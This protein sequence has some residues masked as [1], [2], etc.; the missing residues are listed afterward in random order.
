MN[1]S[2]DKRVGGHPY[3][4]AMTD[5]REHLGF[6][7]ISKCGSITATMFYGLR[8]WQPIET[9]EQ[10]GTPLYTAIRNPV[11][12]LLSSIP[13]T[14][15]RKRLLGEDVSGGFHLPE[16][17]TAA[18]LQI[19]TSSAQGL[20]IE[21]IK[22]IEQMGTFDAHHEGMYKF[23]F[24]DSGKLYGNPVVVQTET[25]SST[26]PRIAARH[27]W[28]QKMRRV[29]PFNSRTRNRFEPDKSLDKVRTYHQN[30]PICRFSGVGPDI[31][32]GTLQTA[33]RE[34]YLGFRE[35]PTVKKVAQAFVE[36]FYPQD[37]FLYEQLERKKT[38]LSIGPRLIEI[39]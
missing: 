29:Q 17:V 15:K 11:D 20:A 25:M 22:V 26:L 35:D 8:R 7:R 19:D 21:F 10:R 24:D 32:A 37:Q 4:M 14:L 2:Y 9:V 39:S 16:N 27:L 3:G 1:F 30:H 18:L 13:E 31:D 34:P 23:L 6:I 5:R 38:L 36:D 33:L 28:L 12:R